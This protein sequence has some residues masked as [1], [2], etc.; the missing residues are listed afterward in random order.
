MS[1]LAYSAVLLLAYSAVSKLAYLVLYS[2]F[3]FR[4]LLE[5]QGHRLAFCSGGNRRA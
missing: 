1:D 3:H 5:S 2:K 4:D